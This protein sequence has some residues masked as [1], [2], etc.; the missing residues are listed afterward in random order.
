MEERREYE[1]E[2]DRGARTTEVYNYTIDFSPF[3][4]AHPLDILTVQDILSLIS[5]NH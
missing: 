3:K 1:G 2:T 5:I 4:T